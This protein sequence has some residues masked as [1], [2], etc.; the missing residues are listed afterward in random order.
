MGPA[1]LIAHGLP[2][3]EL[4]DRAFEL[5]GARPLVAWIGAA[6][7]DQRGWYERVAKVL[8]ERYGAEVEMARTVGEHDGGET[9][10][11]I[12]A[13]A[14][15]YIG[16]GDVSLLAERV[17]A[18][19][20]DEVVRRRH[21]EGEES[22]WEELRALLAAWEREEPGAVV[23]AY[24]IPLGGALEIAPTGTVTHLGPAPKW[25][26]LDCGRIVE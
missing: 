14:M 17:R 22:D 24:G 2:G 3:D 8:R 25:L 23:D 4:H 11:L 21:Q 1:I 6:N 10:R 7:G 9:R 15:I 5:A 13:A 16:G 26:R 12:E 18:L 20:V 19:G